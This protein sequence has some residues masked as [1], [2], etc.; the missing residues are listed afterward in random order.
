MAASQ[1]RC[2]IFKSVYVYDTF[3]SPEVSFFMH[4]G[5]TS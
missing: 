5:G 2:L 1:H 4:K 3:G